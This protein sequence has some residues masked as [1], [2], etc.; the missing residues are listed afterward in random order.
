MDVTKHVEIK[1]KAK[2]YRGQPLIELRYFAIEI[3]GPAAIPQ[4]IVKS[5]ARR[6]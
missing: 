2:S 1:R 6:T 3:R 5:F 4:Y